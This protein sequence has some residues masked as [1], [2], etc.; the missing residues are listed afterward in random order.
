[1]VF[2]PIVDATV[3]LAN[4]KSGGLE[5][6]ERLLATDIKAVQAI[7]TQ[8]FECDRAW[9]SGR[10]AQYR[11]GQD[12]GALSQSEKV[13]QALDLSIDRKTMDQVVFNGEF[14]PGNQWVN[15]KH[16][17]YQEAFPIRLRDIAKAKALLKEAGVTCPSASIHGAEAPERSSRTGD[18]GDGVGGRLRHEDPRH[19]IRDLD[20]AGPGRRVP[21]LHDRLERR[22]DPDGNSYVFL[23]TSAPQND[24]GYSN[25]EADKVLED[26]RLVT[27]PAQRKAIYEKLTRSSSMTSRSSISITARFSSRTPQA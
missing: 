13:R 9:L 7:G 26:G 19:R 1:M 21:D 16:P 2:L 24:S 27:D 3:R 17:Y 8:T 5:L 14:N 10:H 20:E 18:P 12:Q 15:P 4:L 22:T 6:I 23:H 11:Q 25:P